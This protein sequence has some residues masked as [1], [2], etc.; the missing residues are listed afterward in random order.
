MDIIAYSIKTIYCIFFKSWTKWGQ[1]AFIF[2][3]VSKD[4]DSLPAKVKSLKY[5]T[6]QCLEL[7]MRDNPIVACTFPRGW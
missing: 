6:L 2:K 1:G 4:Q 7:A 3:K 5:D